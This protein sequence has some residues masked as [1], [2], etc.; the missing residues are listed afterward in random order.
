[1]ATTFKAL[2]D[3]I[4][5]LGKPVV[6]CHLLIQVLEPQLLPWLNAV[7]Q[8]ATQ[9]GNWASPWPYIAAISFPEPILA[10]LWITIVEKHA[11]SPLL[12][13]HHGPGWCFNCDC[14]LFMGI[15]AEQLYFG[16]IFPK[17]KRCV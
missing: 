8:D 1:M 12:D 11:L 3:S 10:L 15:L 7:N 5:F 9:I 6:P 13:M 2:Q 4:L 14:I 16:C 17:P